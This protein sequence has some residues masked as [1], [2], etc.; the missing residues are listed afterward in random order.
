MTLPL[1]Y[2]PAPSTAVLLW[3]LGA[4][5]H[6]LAEA[7][8]ARATQQLLSEALEDGSLELLEGRILAVT[9]SEPTLRMRFTLDRGRL[10]SAGAGPAD[11]TVTASADDLLLLVARRTDPD[12]LF[13]HR[14]LR[15]SGDTELGLAVK[16]VLDT[17][18]LTRIPAPLQALVDHAADGVERRRAQSVSTPALPR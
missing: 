7:L 11:V 18:D 12:T 15:L 5:P 9:V 16:N 10:H 8:V 13:F 1:P 3:P 17:I 4:L 2:L 14:R 6:P